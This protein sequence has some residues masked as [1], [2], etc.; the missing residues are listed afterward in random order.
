VTQVVLHGGERTH[1]LRGLV[2][3]VGGQF[4]TQV[5][6]GHAAD[7]S[8]GAVHGACDGARGQPAKEDGQRNA[9]YIGSDQHRARL[10]VVCR[11][12]LML[13][14]CVGFLVGDVRVQRILPSL[15]GRAGDLEQHRDRFGV[16]AGM[17]QVDHAVVQA[18]RRL[19]RSRDLV[20]RSLALGTGGQLLQRSPTRV[21][22]LARLHQLGFFDLD[23][24]LFVQQHHRAHHPGD[25]VDRL[26]HLLVQLDPDIVVGD[27]VVQVVFDQGEF[28]ERQPGRS[29]REHDDQSESGSQPNADLV[30]GEF[31]GSSSLS[32]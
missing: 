7:G 25:D 15:G 18:A 8:P 12:L 27:D 2:L 23:L 19:G 3:S 29:D 13:L 26:G 4:D 31:H 21:I 6:F 30:V 28:P 17:G 9:Q 32:E 11:G 16:L 14:F 1:E 20:A 10:L 5:A 22:A 24:G